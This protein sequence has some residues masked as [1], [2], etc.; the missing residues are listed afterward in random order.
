M[1]FR[2]QDLVDRVVS[3]EK[4][5]YPVSTVLY[6][7]LK[8]PGL[9]I[10]R[11]GVSPPDL[12]VY[13]DGVKLPAFDGLSKLE[14]GFF[15]LN[16]GRDILAGTVPTVHFHW[17]HN[18]AEPSGSVKWQLELTAARC[19]G[20]GAFPAAQT[21]SAVSAAPAQYVH[22]E[23]NHVE[24]PA[25]FASILEPDTMLLCRVFRDPTDVQDTFANDA[26]LLMVNLRYRVG[27]NATEEAER[28]FT[29]EGF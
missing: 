15:T 29:A 17:T 12:E 9:T 8:V 24:L 7:D 2:G 1:G 26:F 21:I 25:D 22:T 14:E 6:N 19:M 28:P 11:T 3:L 5:R 4:G 13:R 27:Q 10:A 23:A 16:I 20:A 18:I